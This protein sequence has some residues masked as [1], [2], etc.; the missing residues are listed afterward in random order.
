MK[1]AFSLSLKISLTC[2]LAK[3]QCKTSSTIFLCISFNINSGEL[4]AIVGPVGCGKTTLAKCLGR[5]IELANNQLFIDD[6]DIKILEE[7]CKAK[8]EDYKTLKKQFNKILKNE[9]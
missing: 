8:C 1:I 5:T 2:A 3:P 7:L 4:V 6:I 9:K